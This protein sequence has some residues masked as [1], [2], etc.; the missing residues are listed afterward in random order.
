MYWVLQSGCVDYQ[1]LIFPFVALIL[2]HLTFQ[3]ASICESMYL[4]VGVKSL[5]L[6]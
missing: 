1:M 5:I 6:L 4:N 3:I 2:I